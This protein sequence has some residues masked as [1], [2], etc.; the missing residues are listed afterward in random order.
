MKFVSHSYFKQWQQLDLRRLEC[1][2]GD[3]DN[4]IITLCTTQ[5]YSYCAAGLVLHFLM[6]VYKGGR[7]EKEKNRTT[8]S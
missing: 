5:V 3:S 4:A 2:I 8:M 1:H 7:L 6:W